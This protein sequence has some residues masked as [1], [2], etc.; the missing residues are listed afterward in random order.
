MKLINKI[1]TEVVVLLL[2]INVY[3][4]FAQQNVEITIYKDVIESDFIGFNIYQ[5]GTEIIATIATKT[6]PAVWTGVI[7]LTNGLAS[8][9]A[10]AVDNS[11]NESGQC[12]AYVYDP[13]PGEPTRIEVKV[14][15]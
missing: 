5:D 11:G 8:I 13:A 6:S 2:V 4:S 12:P 7:T 1:I 15:E 3:L 9:T 14:V 10:T